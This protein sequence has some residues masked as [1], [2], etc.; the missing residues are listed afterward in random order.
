VTIEVHMARL[1]ATSLAWF[2]IVVGAIGFAVLVVLFIAPD[3]L[4]PARRELLNNSVPIAAAVAVA[5]LTYLMLKASEGQIG[6][7]DRQVAEERAGR[8]SQGAE[9]KQARAMS[10]QLLVESIKARLD[11]HSPSVTV[12]LEASRLVVTHDGAETPIPEHLRRSE[13]DG[14]QARLHLMFVVSNH[15]P[16]PAVVAHSAVP[17][18]E[19]S[20]YEGGGAEEGRT[21]TACLA[22]GMSIKIA[23]NYRMGLP[24]WGDQT[25]RGWLPPPVPSNVW[26]L[27]FSFTSRPAS[28][29]TIDRHQF[30]V[31]LQPF[32]CQGVIWNP[33]PIHSG[34][35]ARW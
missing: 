29:E 9:A 5:A 27:D 32:R 13:F 14:W 34:S 10:Q 4:D 22:P 19:L 12:A 24:A 31:Q 1:L 33:T 6:A 17:H 11:A 16:G 25:D 30:R 20:L 3:L 35:T 23:W 2:F 7:L 28:G 21:R 8:Q 15:G 26:M 18:G